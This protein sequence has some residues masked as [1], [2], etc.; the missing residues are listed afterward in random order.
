MAE[1]PNFKPNSNKYREKNS[2]NPEVEH[3][4]SKVAK[5]VTKKSQAS[6]FQKFAKAFLPED[7]KSIKDYVIEETPGFIMGFLRRLLQNIL[8]TYLPENGRYS[9]RGSSVFRSGGSGIRYDTIR[10]G[11]STGGGVKSRRTNT[12]YEY[13]NVVFE[14]YADAEEV[15]D[16]LYDC[17]EQYEKVRVFD[18]YDLAGV[19]AKSTDRDYGWTD[20]RGTHIISVKEGWVI[21]LPRAIPLI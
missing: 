3:R 1:L 5:G 8:D 21:E 19:A 7:A 10:T 20:L 13:E 2:T 4:V 12:V 17:L 15:L 18:L 16:H 6:S 14:D 11:A 9:S